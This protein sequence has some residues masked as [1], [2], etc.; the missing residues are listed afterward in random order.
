[1]GNAWKMRW[2]AQRGCM[3]I[4]E[5]R[6][7]RGFYKACKTARAGREA[8]LDT[9]YPDHRKRWRTTIWKSPRG[10]R[11]QD[12]MLLL[13]RARGLAPV[14]VPLPSNLGEV[15]AAAFLEARRV[16]DR[17]ARHY[18]WHLVVEDGSVPLPAAGTT[19]AA[20]DLGEIHP[21][22]VTDGTETVIISCRALRANQQYTAK[23][24]AEIRARQHRKKKYSRSC[25]PLQRRKNRL[26]F[27][28]EAQSPRDGAQGESRR[29]HLGEGTPGEY[30][31]D[32]RWARCRGWQAL[33]RQ[34][35]AEDWPLVTW[36]AAS[37]HH[38]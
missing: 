8:G 28:T 21:A 26:P 27:K 37:V 16:S 17:A 20:G 19:T 11:L 38:L 36:K 10:I 12:K 5:T 30:A 31:G 13:A 34:K 35:P 14:L 23:R 32:W 3:P 6:R 22:A 29:C 18:G 9:K 24:L 1:M 15:P 33:E 25:K 7:S 4:A 2:A